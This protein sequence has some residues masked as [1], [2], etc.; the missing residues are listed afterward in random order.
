MSLTVTHTAT[1]QCDRCGTRSTVD[2][3]DG[4]ATDPHSDLPPGWA[5]LSIDF[6]RQE[7]DTREL[8]GDCLARLKAVLEIQ[9]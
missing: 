4:G 7:S 9:K 6:P 5:W 2:H 8:C 1:W 3:V